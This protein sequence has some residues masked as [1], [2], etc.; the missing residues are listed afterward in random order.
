MHIKRFLILGL[1]VANLAL[2]AGLVVL[3]YDLPQ[4]YAQRSGGGKYLAVTAE[5]TGGTDALYLL[6]TRKNVMVVLIPEQN[7]SGRLFVADARD[8]AADLGR[9]PKR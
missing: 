4:A 8:I 9:Q 3:S 5:Y 6:H 2:L 7:Q 1:V